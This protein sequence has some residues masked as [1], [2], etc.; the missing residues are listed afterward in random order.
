MTLTDRFQKVPSRQK[1]AIGVLLAALIVGVYYALLY[2]TLLTEK[3]G[4]ERDHGRLSEERR[5]YEN[6]KQEYLQIRSEIGRLLERQKENERILPKR[7]EIASLLDDIHAQADLSGL[8]VQTFEPKPEQPQQYHVKIPVGM[9]VSGTF[10][11]LTKFFHYVGQLKRIVNVEDVVVA[12]PK[13]EGKQV[14]VTGTFMAVAFRAM[15][16]APAAPATPGAPR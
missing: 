1:I 6:Q 12:T 15:D 2:S 5:T 14:I 7:D 13:A 4:L 9:S 11:G 3:E 10:H 16:R 8:Q